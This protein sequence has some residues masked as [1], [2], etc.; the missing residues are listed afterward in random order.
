VYTYQNGN[1]T[2]TGVCDAAIGPHLG[3][4]SPTAYFDA[5]FAANPVMP[6][7]PWGDPTE[8]S[9]RDWPANVDGQPLPFNA[10]PAVSPAAPEAKRHTFAKR[11]GF[12]LPSTATAAH[13]LS[14]RSV[15]PSASPQLTSLG[16][17]FQYLT[18]GTPISRRYMSFGDSSTHAHVK[19]WE[20]SKGVKDAQDRFLD[21]GAATTQAIPL[22]AL[23]QLGDA[24]ANGAWGGGTECLWIYRN[25]AIRVTVFGHGADAT[26]I[27]RALQPKIAIAVA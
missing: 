7:Q 11:L 13:P 17:K 26:E 3:T 23:S 10:A 19:I 21:E 25:L 1:D 8:H 15:D 2:L 14:S 16:M 20:S 5:A 18:P 4:E 27:A 22:N 24:A 6:P 9:S 12:A